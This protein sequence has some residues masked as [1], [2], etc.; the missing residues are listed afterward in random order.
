[1][2]NKH[3]QQLESSASRIHWLRHCPGSTI[4]DKAGWQ[5]KKSGAMVCGKIDF[6]E[7]VIYESCGGTLPWKFQHGCL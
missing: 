3:C 2:S 1:M 7:N 4:R 6:I 5:R